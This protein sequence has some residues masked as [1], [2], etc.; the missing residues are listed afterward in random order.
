MWF[1][2]IGFSALQLAVLP[3]CP[4]SP[5][6]LIKS[7]GRATTLRTLLCLHRE[8]SAARH[9]DAL[10]SEVQAVKGDMTMLELLRAVHLR[11][12]ADTEPA[13]LYRVQ[14]HYLSHMTVL[15]E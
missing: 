15:Y 7:R 4:D 9:L 8:D 10:T 2:P 11:K 14:S 13:V 3:F 5:S 12:Q 1:V 6:F